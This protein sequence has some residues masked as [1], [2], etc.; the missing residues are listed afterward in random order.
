MDFIR[1][2]GQ[3]LILKDIMKGTKKEEGWKDAFEF[4][5][6]LYE[7]TQSEILKQMKYMLERGVEADFI[8]QTLQADNEGYVVS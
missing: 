2:V 3:L 5:S 6:W 1:G 4:S 7:D 8:I